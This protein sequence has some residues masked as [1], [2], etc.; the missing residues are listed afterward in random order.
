[1]AFS[2]P[3]V[4]SNACHHCPIAREG[5]QEHSF[6]L[7]DYRLIRCYFY[8]DTDGE[9]RGVAKP[10][11]RPLA[12]VEAVQHLSDC[13]RVGP[14]GGALPARGDARGAAYLLTRAAPAMQVVSSCD[15]VPPE[16]PMAPMIL[17]SGPVTIRDSQ[18]GVHLPAKRRQDGRPRRVR[19]APKAAWHHNMARSVGA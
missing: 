7:T 18:V 11:Y 10:R 9:D 14:V 13:F 8:R 12:I 6:A 19:Q 1:M 15:P 2:N 3:L 5:A 17:P 4:R 16:Q